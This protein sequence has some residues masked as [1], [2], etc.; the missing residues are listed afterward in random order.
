MVQKNENR[1]GYKK[2]KVGWIPEEWECLPFTNVF[3]RVVVSL[4]PVEM[5]TYQEIGVRSHGKGIFH[6]TPIR[7]VDLGSKRVFHCQP[8]ALVFNIVFAWEQAVAVLSEQERGLIASHRFPMYQGKKGRAFEPFFLSFFKTR[9]GKNGLNIASPG[10]AGRNKTLGQKE[11]DYLYVPIPTMSEQEAI[12]GVLECWD[13]A[14]RGYERKIEVKRAVKK[15]LMQGLLTGRSRLPGFGPELG[16]KNSECGIPDGW[17]EVRLGEVCSVRRGASPRPIKDPKWFAEQ[18][19]G[20]VR[21]S[22]VTKCAKHLR[23]T[24]QYL[25]PDGEANSVSVDPGDLI[26]SICATIGVPRIVDIPVCIHDGFVV[27]RDIASTDTLFLFYVLSEGTER[28]AGMGQPGTQKNLNAMI[29][30]QIRVHLPPLDEQR[31]IASVLSTADGEIDALGRKLAGLK[32]QKRYLLNNLVTGT[33]RLP[34]FRKDS[35]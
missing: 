22:D 18:G 25:S 3:N 11:M 24:S 35:P 23:S 26:M 30:R 15:G 4:T 32:D 6:K 20:W 29:V 13:K 2:T 9:K 7:G 19:R 17:K 10:G 12:A 1:P 31:A 16:I 27:L 14:I 21:I 8:G 28:L 33:I 5:R 34:E